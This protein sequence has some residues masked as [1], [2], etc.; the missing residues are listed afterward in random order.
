MPGTV[1][2]SLNQI[3]ITL[4]PGDA[5]V[6][7]REPPVPQT[8][9]LSPSLGARRTS[10]LF[11]CRL[12]KA[13]SDELDL[14]LSCTAPVNKP[15][16]HE[17]TAWSTKSR[18]F[19][20]EPRVS[21]SL[22]ISPYLRRRPAMVSAG[23]SSYKKEWDRGW[24]V[25]MWC[26]HLES[27]EEGLRFITRAGSCCSLLRE[28]TAAWL[29]CTLPIATYVAN[30]M[31]LSLSEILKRCLL[32][33]YPPEELKENMKNYGSKTTSD[34]WDLPL[35][36]CYFRIQIK[37]RKTVLKNVDIR[38]ITEQPWDC[39]HSGQVLVFS[40]VLFDPRFLF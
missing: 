15:L 40:A 13:A 1:I 38:R 32:L 36:Y 25:E 28:S 18:G 9:F 34:L 19:W 33:F 7:Y 10:F 20:K 11:F 37:I 30:S 27:E 6:P 2:S 4:P 35:C 29:V 14:S 16:N 12:C 3:K 26:L 5:L 8:Q 23:S 31:G 17:S 21:A 22:G 39:G 24:M